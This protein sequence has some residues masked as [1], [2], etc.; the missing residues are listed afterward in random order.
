MAHPS[1]RTV[2]LS[3]GAALLGAGVLGPAAPARPGDPVEN[4]V[5]ANVR[6]QV[7]ALLAGSDLIAGQI[8]AGRLRIVGARYDLENG[9]V[10]LVH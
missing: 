3:G 7:A 5:V 4:A 9:R 1:R 8:A 6:A 2:L 10:S